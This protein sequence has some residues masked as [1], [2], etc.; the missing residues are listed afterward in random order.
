MSP[1]AHRPASLE[2]IVLRAQS[3]HCQ[4]VD[5]TGTRWHALQRGRLKS[6]PRVSLTVVVAGDRVRFHPLP[7]GRHEAVLEE[8][9]PRRNRV[10]RRT[11]RRDRGRREQ[12]LMANLDQLL[13]VQSVTRPRPVAGFVDRLLAAAAQHGTTGL[14]CSATST[15]RPPPRVAGTGTGGWVTACCCCRP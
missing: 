9:L 6:G 10:S 7:H 15:R 2:G 12:V 3:G 13:V 8:V 11:S 14:L 1:T 4:V 5:R